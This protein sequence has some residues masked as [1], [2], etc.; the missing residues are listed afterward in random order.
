[1]SD[2]IASCK[3]AVQLLHTSAMSDTR[4]T[5]A[6][7]ESEAGPVAALVKA[8][9]PTALADADP[10]ELLQCLL[11]KPRQQRFVNILM[12]SAKA[13]WAAYHQ[14]LSQSRVPSHSGVAEL[15]SD[16]PIHDILAVEK[17]LIP[18]AAIAATY[19][20]VAEIAATVRPHV[21]DP[22][23]SP[24]AKL[25]AVYDAFRAKG[26]ITI[27]GES[28]PFVAD[29]V[30]KRHFDCDTASLL[31]VAVAH[32]LGWPVTMVMA[33]EHAFVRWED[34]AGTV[35]FDLGEIHPTGYY[36]KELKIDPLAVHNGLYLRS[37]TPQDMV[38]YALAVR[39][40]AQHQR[41][42][43]T[44]AHAD[45]DQAL[46]LY[47]NNSMALHNRG[48]CS[49]EQK[50]YTAA[51][52]DFNTV[53]ALDPADANA[54]CLRG[55]VKEIVNGPGAGTSDWDRALELDAI[56]MGKV[57]FY[58]GQSQEMA[59]H[60][61]E[62]LME[63]RD[64]ILLTADLPD[65]QRRLFISDRLLGLTYYHCGLIYRRQGNQKAAK[66]SFFLAHQL[67]PTLP[68]DPKTGE[69]PR[70]HHERTN[71]ERRTDRVRTEKHRTPRIV[72]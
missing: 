1:M 29:A 8:E 70:R 36:L 18:P 50:E 59:G 17:K 68:E 43:L 71:T 30:T 72:D 57:S 55:Q 38:S 4:V 61:D 22:Q 35:N 15:R 21:T 42:H 58:K 32:E 10:D 20:L 66:D 28:I 48:S 16:N 49:A 69:E 2:P 19:A 60:D 26:F 44:E 31:L 34:A 46:R 53:I 51:L 47:P 67:Q 41:G 12:G 39:G 65:D 7:C 13:A 64:I 52:A 3:M 5:E 24:E 40:T 27:P 6:M 62:A 45:Y 9:C 25:R 33:P 11:L 37:L 63:F 56:S 23:Q 54:Y 14:H